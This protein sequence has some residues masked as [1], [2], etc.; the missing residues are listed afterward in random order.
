MPLLFH[1]G[2][3]VWAP[4]IGIAADY[5]SEADDE[6]LEPRWAALPR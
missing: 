4:G 5:R 6:G 3:L 2:R 1:G